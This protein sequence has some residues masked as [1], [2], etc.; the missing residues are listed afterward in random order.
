ML[1]TLNS[2]ILPKM[3]CFTAFS[4]LGC[5]A[6]STAVS[7]QN[8]PEKP[9]TMVVPFNAG[10]AAD[11]T[12]RV[13]A[14]AMS[15]HLGQNVL[16]ENVGGAGGAI[17]TARVAKAEPDGYTI[18]LGHMGTLAAA[19]T[20]NRSLQYDPRKDLKY[21]GLVSTS[22]NVIYVGKDFPAKNLEEFIDH[23]KSA[24]GAPAMGHGGIGAASHVA[25]VMLFKLIGVEPN[26]IAYKGFG[27]TITDVLGGRIAGGCDLLASA[28]PIAK[29]GSIRILAIAAQKRSPVLPDAPTSA[30]AGLPEFLT[31]TW[32][33]LF[34]PVGTPEA[35]VK[36][37]NAALQN[38]LA[39]NNVR[40]KLGTI[41]ASLPPDD[42]RSGDYMQDLVNREIAA[43][44]KFLKPE[45][46]N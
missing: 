46:Q 35:V 17:G 22:P 30:E 11:A 44:S 18:G 40:E 10:G 27:Q 9:I 32:T 23:A 6:N 43:W 42:H 34:V 8:F 38:S 4:M 20:I 28:A 31:E 25:C 1:N 24:K 12:G 36:T 21:L 37:L 2:K 39:Q 16:V 14:E 7:A 3:L 41:G 26:L 45:Q 15:R 33:G 19:V 5:I 13:I 29:A